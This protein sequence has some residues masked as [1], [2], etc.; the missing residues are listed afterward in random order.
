M[1]VSLTPLQALVSMCQHQGQQPCW[2]IKD[3]QHHTVLYSMVLCAEMH[4]HC[5]S[6]HALLHDKLCVCNNDCKRKQQELQKKA[7]RIAK[8]S[9]NNCTDIAK[10]L[11]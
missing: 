1:I 11:Q 2:T 4:M 6:T 5:A 9:S 10:Q 8:E 7:T 3:A